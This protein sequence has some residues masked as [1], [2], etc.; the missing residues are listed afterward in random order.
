MLHIAAEKGCEESFKLLLEKE[1]SIDMWK[2]SCSTSV[3]HCSAENPE[4]EATI[5]GEPHSKGCNIN[6]GLN[7]DVGSVLTHAV[8]AKN[9]DAIKYLIN[10]NAKMEPQSKMPPLYFILLSTFRIL[11]FS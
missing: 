11:I 9:I 5:I 3:M 1:N 6:A 4:T 7:T 10:N 2:G 8:Q